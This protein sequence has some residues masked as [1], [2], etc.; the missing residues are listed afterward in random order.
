MYYDYTHKPQPKPCCGADE[1]EDQ[2]PIDFASIAQIVREA[3]A[4]PQNINV[5]V[6]MPGMQPMT[7]VPDQK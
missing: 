4:K 1:E 7:A 2:K 3:V 6:N 5:T